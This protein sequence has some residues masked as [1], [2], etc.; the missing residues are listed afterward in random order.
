MNWQLWAVVAYLV[1]N[2]AIYGSKAGKER[3]PIGGVEIACGVVEVAAVIALVV[4]GA[5][6]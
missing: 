3:E 1:V 2:F 6:S 5:T 4:W